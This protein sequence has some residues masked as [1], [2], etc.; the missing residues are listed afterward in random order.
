MAVSNALG[1][2]L[3]PAANWLRVVGRWRRDWLIGA[4]TLRMNWAYEL[5]SQSRQDSSG[6]ACQGASRDEEPGDGERTAR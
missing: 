1:G 6:G 4:A 3:G 2:S 5:V